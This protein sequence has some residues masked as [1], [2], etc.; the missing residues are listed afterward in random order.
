MVTISGFVSKLNKTRILSFIVVVLMVMGYSYARMVDM[1]VGDGGWYMT[2]G[3]ACMNEAGRFDIRLFPKT[4][5]GCLFPLL[6]QLVKSVVNV[7]FGWSI[8]T[9]IMIAI[10]F[11]IILPFFFKENKNQSL[12]MNIRGILVAYLFLTVFGDNIVYTLSDTFTTFFMLFGIILLLI[13][14]DEEKERKSVI[15]SVVAGASFYIAYNTR[16]AF[17]YG[18]V[19]AIIAFCISYARRHK[20]LFACI[21]GFITGIILLSIPQCIVN[22][23]HE[24]MYSPRVYT[25]NYSM[26]SG[27]D[28][29]LQMQQIR[30]GLNWSR[31]EAYVGGVVGEYPTVPMYYNDDVSGEIVA[32]EGIG[33]VI[34][35]KEWFDMWLKYPLDMI[36]VYMRHVISAMTPN[37]KYQYIPD[38]RINASLIVFLSIS[39]WLLASVNIVLQPNR[40]RFGTRNWYIIAACIPALLQ[41]LGAV[42]VRFFIPAYILCYGYVAYGIDYKALIAAAKPIWLKISI[43]LLLVFALWISCFGDIL[44]NNDKRI[45]LINNKELEIL[46]EDG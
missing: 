36:G 33:E 35:L 28:E 4:F 32:R 2:I 5:R 14:E 22:Y 29:Q 19:V 7:R 46:N 21:V 8:I 43:I 3:D 20:R 24:G 39:L 38:L 45:F 25:E 15:L 31:F 16:A 26:I 40:N 30:W 27:S 13:I 41:S 18:I 42:E 44:S 17:L 23:T 11:T 6:L 9:S 1:T 10:I 12:F 37:W 34:T